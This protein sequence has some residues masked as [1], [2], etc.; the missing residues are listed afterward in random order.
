[1]ADSSNTPTVDAIESVLQTVLDPC[2]CVSS[3]PTSIVDLGLVEE[4]AV[5]GD[6][7]SVELVL[8]SPSCAYFP[9][10]RVEIVEKIEMCESVSADKIVV[11]Q[12]T[13]EVWGRDRMSQAE[14]ERRDERFR[15]RVAEEGLSP[16]GTKSE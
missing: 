2:S 10:I 1:M 3:D 5:D 6:V 13:Q 12:N 14:R 16:R 8:T 11:T 4:I 7:V 9:H 15:R